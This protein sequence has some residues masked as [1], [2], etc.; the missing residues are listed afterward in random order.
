M[1]ETQTFISVIEMQHEL[2]IPIDDLC[3]CPKMV[4]TASPTAKLFSFDFGKHR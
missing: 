4:E 3:N 1:P 2:F